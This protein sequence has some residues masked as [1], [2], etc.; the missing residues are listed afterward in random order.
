MYFQ[1]KRR[2][3]NKKKEDLKF[4]KV[5]HHTNSSTH[6][7]I[8]RDTNKQTNI[9]TSNNQCFVRM[10]LFVRNFQNLVLIF[11]CFDCDNYFEFVE[12]SPIRRQLVVCNLVE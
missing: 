7:I 3:K 6:L 9:S 8:L 5:V 11:T 10:F 4:I 12:V 1:T 2:E